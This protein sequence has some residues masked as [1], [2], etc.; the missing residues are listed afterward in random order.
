MVEV[1][2]IYK[3][4]NQGEK[5]KKE[6]EKYIKLLEE[7]RREL[8]NRKYIYKMFKKLEGFPPTGRTLLFSNSTKRSLI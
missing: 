6:R 5:M 3:T 8:D 1:P 4:S 7:T 2:T